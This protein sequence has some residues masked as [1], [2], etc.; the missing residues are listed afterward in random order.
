[1]FGMNAWQ[2]V[3]AALFSVVIWLFVRE[4]KSRRMQ[5][6]PRVTWLIWMLLDVF[7]LI[8]AVQKDSLNPLIVLATG[9]AFLVCYLAVGYG[10]TA[11]TT[12]DKWCL[13]LGLVTLVAWVWSGDGEL[14]LLM[15]LFV[16]L[17]GVAPLLQRRWENPYED[18][19]WLYVIGILSSV[20]TIVGMNV[21]GKWLDYAQPATFLLTQVATLFVLVVRRWFVP[22][23]LPKRVLVV[24]DAAA[25]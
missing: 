4:V 6:L 21:N 15:S 20:C 22:R 13:G 23:P 25:E 18:V 24:V 14:A 7:V 19:P 5:R 16:I 2:A 8:A 17:V 9:Q 1:M 10:D 12:L 3:G 11:W